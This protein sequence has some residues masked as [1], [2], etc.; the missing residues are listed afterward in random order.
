LKFTLEYVA[1]LI[2]HHYGF[3]GELKMLPGEV[4]FNYRL[5]TSKGK[6]IVKIASSD[7]DLARLQMQNEVLIHVREHVPDV[8][9]Q[10]VIQNVKGEYLTHIQDANGATRYLRILTYLEGDLWANI[11]PHTPA[12]LEHLGE[13]L[14]LL[15]RGL[16]GYDHPAAHFNFK[17]DSSQVGTWIEPHVDVIKDP[18]QCAIIDHFLHLF[19]TKFLPQKN[20]LRQGVHQND[21]NDYNVLISAEK[22]EITGILD[23]GDTVYTHTV[24]E[25]AIAIAYAAINK[26][27]PL[28]A[29]ANV[30][31][32]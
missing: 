27:D 3:Q 9:T 22:Q 17:W 23:F 15:C 29:A 5:T 13:S 24:N 21:A 16:S 14:G 18:A 8:R 6:Y 25:L 30:V 19:K 4:D 10:D 1:R 12:L 31:R 11:R 32:N 26:P 7:T 28:T 2:D 20:N